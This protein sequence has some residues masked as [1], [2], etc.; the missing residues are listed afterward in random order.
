M[1][2]GRWNYS[3]QQINQPMFNNTKTL[4]VDYCSSN[5]YEY[6]Y[7]SMNYME[8][9]YEKSSQQH[10]QNYECQPN[11]YNEFS[12]NIL[13]QPRSYPYMSEFANEYRANAPSF[14]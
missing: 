14:I 12:M 2:I 7:P 13:D 11:R 9:E 10:Y 4:P 5:K 6:R 8:T 1:N 3:E